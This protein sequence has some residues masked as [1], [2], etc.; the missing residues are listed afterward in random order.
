M[1]VIV[2]TDGSRQSLAAAKHLKSFADPGKVTD[3]SVVAVIRPLASV[4]FADDLSEENKW[5]AGSFRD[6]A[7]SA[8]AT[9][10]KVFD[11]WGPK[12]HKRIRSGSA[13]NEIIK[14]AKQY[15][16]GL[17][18]VAAGGRGLSDAVLLGSTAQRVQHYAPCP[19]LVVRPAPRKPRKR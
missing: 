3:I 8:V 13:A 7:E 15:D 1:H 16:A 18:V 19:V 4:A 17:V 5:P 14:A 11:G 2:A 10:A 9:I 12:V 6:A